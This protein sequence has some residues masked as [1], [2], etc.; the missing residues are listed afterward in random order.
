MSLR[1]SQGTGS[2]VSKYGV[3]LG[4]GVVCLCEDHVDGLLEMF[5]VRIEKV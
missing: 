2:G 3:V 5:V 1:G 4:M